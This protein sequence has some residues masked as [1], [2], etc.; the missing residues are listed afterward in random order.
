V[1]DYDARPGGV[2]ADDS[3]V[4]GEGDEYDPKDRTHVL[5]RIE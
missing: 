2:G 4:E 5:G 3:D 1:T